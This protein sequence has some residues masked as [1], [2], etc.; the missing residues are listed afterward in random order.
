M[1][2]IGV[3]LNRIFEKNT[4]TT[5]L[6]GFFY[7]TVVTV[8]P[9]FVIIINLILMEYL[10]DFASV[11]YVTREL[12]S[13]TI[14]YTFIF[15]LLTASP[16]N[17]VLSR[18]MSD[19]I[20]EERYQ[21]ILPCYHIGMLLNIGLSCLLGIPFCLWEHFVGKVPTA[22]VFCGFCGYI[23]LVL[24]FYS[25]IYLSICKDYQRISQYF[26][27]GMLVAFVLALILHFILKWETTWS[28][29]FSL[30]IGFFVTATLENALIRRYFVRNSNHYRPVLQY[31]RKYWK[32]I[33]TNFLYILGLYIHN[34]VFW[35]T[36]MR[37][38]I[39]KSFVCNQPYDMASCLA[40]FTNISATIIF[41]ARVEMNFHEKY[42]EKK[43]G[44]EE[45]TEKTEGEAAKKTGEKEVEETV[46]KTENRQDAADL[47][48]ELIEHVPE[49]HQNGNILIRNKDLTVCAWE[50]GYVL[51]FPALKN[52]YEI[53]M[54]A[55]GSFACI[56][57]RLPMTEEEQDSLFLAIR[58]V[59]LFLAQKKGMFVLHSAS[60]LYLEKAWL[61][62]GPS[63]MGKST[64]TALWKKLF[65]T[66]FLNGDLNLI[67]K[68]GDQF[69]VYGIPW[70]GTSEIFT[71]EKKELG[72]IVLLEKAPEDKIVSL[73]KEQ[74]TLRVMQRMISPPWTAGL[75]KKNLAFAE[76]I[77]NEK[78][79]YFLRCTKNDTAAE[80]MHHRITEDELAQEALK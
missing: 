45:A 76:E 43:R 36:D 16:F 8:A 31:F 51:W 40:M 14:L 15:S 4:L 78:P 72:G 66:P 20:Y 38:E 39:A 75:M 73:T 77:A 47:T 63:G 37:M 2:G 32:L 44:K 46:I 50:E 13:C 27:F 52:I 1:A 74:K 67:G 54:E 28:M 19:V 18:Y 9:M 53:W 10:L 21:D 79:V 33:F 12:F 56:Y 3:R 7:S 61:F 71:V 11:G 49:S 68:E 57:Y 24:V 6:V 58:P 30:T 70:C 60:L 62:S 29:L 23:S 48:L 41:I 5:N 80:V 64:H 17:A 26:F 69:V 59:F 55:D 25:M 35:T 65:D 22:Y 34:F 42:N